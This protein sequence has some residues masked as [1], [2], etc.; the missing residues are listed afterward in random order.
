MD[1][2]FLREVEEYFG[3]VHRAV[4]D[5]RMSNTDVINEIPPVLLE[6]LVGTPDRSGIAAERHLPFAPRDP[7][8]PMY[9]VVGMAMAVMTMT[10]T[11]QAV[12]EAGLVHLGI[13]YHWRRLRGFMSS[14]VG[15]DEPVFWMRALVQ[16]EGLE[17]LICKALI[18]GKKITSR[19]WLH[20]IK[21]VT[22]SIDVIVGRFQALCQRA[23]ELPA[24]SRHNDR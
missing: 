5:G 18:V 14:A 19:T 24:V 9:E 4:R 22:V 17:D 7:Y 3:G 6:I 11:N 21:D 16:Y 20:D 15:V 13:E 12:A 1:G 8:L 2:D 10:L 23:R